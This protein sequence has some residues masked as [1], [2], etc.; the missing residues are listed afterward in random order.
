MDSG[1]TIILIMD[2][3]FIQDITGMHP[4]LTMGEDFTTIRAVGGDLQIITRHIPLPFIQIMED[5]KD[6]I[7][8]K[9]GTII[10][11]ILML[12]SYPDQDRSISMR[13][14]KQ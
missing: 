11:L 7:D 8:L 12:L 1:C 6:I 14:I 3:D 10:I 13:G 5:A 4:L 9:E 2:G